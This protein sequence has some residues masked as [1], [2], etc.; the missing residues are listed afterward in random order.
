M[1]RMTGTTIAEAW[2]G[3]RNNFNLI[4]L[5]AAWMVIYGHA[6]AITGTAG[7]DAIARLTHI[8]FAG[9]VAVDMFFV[10]SGFLI[11]ATTRGRSGLAAAGDFLWR[12]F[13][14]VGRGG[15]ERGR[16]AGGGVRGEP[17]EDGRRGG[18]DAAPA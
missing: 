11:A 6:W 13:R 7:G 2:A 16:G 10:I 17:G 4:R 3:G 5:V 15:S 12:R 1:P 8:K 9:A 14:R 18:A